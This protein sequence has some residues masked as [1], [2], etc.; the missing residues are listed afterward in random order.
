M[1]GLGRGGD[2]HYF[3]SVLTPDGEAPCPVP[4]EA[5]VNDHN[6]QREACQNDC[7]PEYR[8]ELRTLHKFNPVICVLGESALRPRSKFAAYVVSAD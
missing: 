3:K 6:E 4:F 7:Q 1:S 8:A 2:P 5:R